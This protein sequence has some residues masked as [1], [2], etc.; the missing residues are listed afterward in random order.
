[1]RLLLVE[2]DEILAE[3]IRNNLARL[4]YNL[5]WAIDGQEGWDYSQ[6]IAYDLILLDVGLPKINGLELCARLR[7]SG[8]TIPILL[9]TARE[10]TSERVRGL[11]TG[12]DDYL[13]K[14]VNI[15]ELQARIRALLRRGEVLPSS[16][17]EIG[18]LKL[19]P[20][21]CEVTYNDTEGKRPA[22]SLNLTP[23]EYQILELFMRNPSRVFSRGQIIEQLW[24]FDDCPL[25]DSVKAHIKGLRQKLKAVNCDVAVENV[26][27]L[28]YRLQ[29]PAKIAPDRESQFQEAQSQLWEKY[30][31]AMRE[32]LGVLQRAASSLVSGELK[33]DLQEEAKVAAHKLAGVLGMFERDRGSA[34]A[35]QI[36]TLLAADSV[37][38][39][40]LCDLVQ[41]LGD[42]LNLNLTHST[43]RSLSDTAE[44]ILLISPDK[45]LLV[46]LEAE[47][48]S[49]RWQGVLDVARARNWLMDHH[50]DAVVISV[51]AGGEQSQLV[52]FISELARK[53]PPIPS[54]VIAEE[55]LPNLVALAKAGLNIFLAQPVTAEQICST[56]SALLQRHDSQSLRVLIVDDDAVFLAGLRPLFES[57]GMKMTG[58]SNP[59]R[60]LEVLK[61][62]NPD[63][64]ILDVE[65]PG[66]TGMELCKLIRTSPEWQDL[67]AL[68]LSANR[69]MNTI[70][71]IFASGGDDYLIKPV[72]GSELLN[73]IIL[74][75]DRKRVLDTIA[76]R[77]WLTGVN[78]QGQSQS[79]LTEL[80]QR[81]GKDNRPVSLVLLKLP[82][83]Q[84]INRQYGHDMGNQILRYWGSCL[85]THFHG[86]RELGY[87]GDGE[88]IIAL[89][90]LRRQEAY[91]QITPLLG[92]LRKYIVTTPT[93]ERLQPLCEAVTVEF[94]LDGGSLHS[95]YQKAIDSL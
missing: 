52:A 54:L 41:S 50:A 35:K 9:M 25:E 89:E 91:E 94:P 53:T 19:N 60:F 69:D 49:Y 48:P 18:K 6:S 87:W 21:S 74:R 24:S 26:Y 11:D 13:F 51:D 47:A 5:D 7:R 4:R 39:E 32:R 37:N 30:Q 72:R 88:F 77:D 73:R 22:R 23:K 3:V 79:L 45:T 44:S 14:P 56:L 92:A 1:M 20:V 29:P 65:M 43:G 95:L 63:L 42:E 70:Q 17:L 82:E 68:F 75:Y 16:I 31:G 71:E 64:L 55:I 90:G 85:Q 62:V 66:L 15:E 61:S 10:D 67:P 78:H 93:G 83:I 28:G 59:S 81:A 27:G 46:A 84:K 36:E 40:P 80:L 34:I 8:C 12:A 2:D 33:P 76:R 57:W 38:L 86:L 58:L